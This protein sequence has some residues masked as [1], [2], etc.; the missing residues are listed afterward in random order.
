MA[1][2]YGIYLPNGFISG[3]ICL[4]VHFWIDPAVAHLVDRIIPDDPLGGGNN[5]GNNAGNNAGN[6]NDGEPGHQPA[7]G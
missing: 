3:I 7:E 5:N 2:I 6:A 4:I 1:R